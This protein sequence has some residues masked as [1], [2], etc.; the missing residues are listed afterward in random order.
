MVSAAT[1][2][3]AGV[4]RFTPA[5]SF[6]HMRNDLGANGGGLYLNRYTLAF[7]FTLDRALPAGARLCLFQPDL[8][9]MIQTA[10]FLIDASGAT[11]VGDEA[12]A[13]LPAAI[14]PHEWHHVAVSVSTGNGLNGQECV[15]LI[16]LISFFSNSQCALG[17]LPV[18]SIG[19]ATRA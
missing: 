8:S 5:Q 14:V 9:F 11:H 18:D 10:A 6:V 16:S 19:G 4:L 13:V 15:V 7:E 12:G 3:T 2:T 17:V 1:H